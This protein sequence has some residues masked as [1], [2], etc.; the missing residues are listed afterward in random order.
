VLRRGDERGRE[1]DLGGATAAVGDAIDEKASG[2][3]ADLVAALVDA[4]QR[5]RTERRERG[6]VVTG[7]GDVVRN[8]KAGFG[9]RVERAHGDD[10][11]AS[12]DGGRPF[13]PGEQLLRAQI[14]ALLGVR[15]RHDVD[16]IGQTMCPHGL[17]VTVGPDGV[18]H[19]CQ[20]GRVL[21]Q[22]LDVGDPA[23]AESGQ[24]TDDEARAGEVVV[25]DRVVGG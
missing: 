13:G 19:F 10:V 14:T 18:R 5:D 2:I 22:V 23:V 17:A 11:G 20:T 6:V 25:G 15:R 24:V 9:E 21:F 12:E 4:R 3:G 1:P 8:R 16:L 7:D